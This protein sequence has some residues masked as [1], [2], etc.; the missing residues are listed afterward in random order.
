MLGISTTGHEY[1]DLRKVTR[2]TRRRKEREL[3]PCPL[4]MSTFTEECM[5]DDM[6]L[7]TSR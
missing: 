1:I 2:R 3:H 7:N 6:T 5:C 4:K